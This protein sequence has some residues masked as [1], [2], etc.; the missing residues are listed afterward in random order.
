[1][2]DCQ[3]SIISGYSGM[4]RPVTIV[5]GGLAGLALGIGLRQSD[6]TVTLHEASLYPRHRVCGEFLSGRG[7]QVLEQLGLLDKLFKAGAQTA[8]TISFHTPSKST[9]P[10]PLP[11]P[12]LCLSR[13]RLDHLLAEEFRRSGGH[14]IQNS[15]WTSSLSAEG[16]IRATG[17]RAEQHP[18]ESILGMKIHLRDLPLHS[19][20]EMHFTPTAYFG[21]CRIEDEKV[22][23]CGLF[24]ISDA[25]KELARDRHNIFLRYANHS[26]RDRLRTA[27][28]ELESFCSVA[29]LPLR[30]Q[31]S[32]PKN[33][34]SLGDSLAM[35]PPVTGN[36]MSLALESAHLTLQHALRFS[37]NELSWPEALQLAQSD[38]HRAFSRRL[39]WASQ[40]HN[41]LFSPAIQLLLPG[42]LSR[43]PGLLPFLFHRTRG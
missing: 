38:F 40:L 12:A 27:H 42:A 35:I 13:Y 16:L 21:L 7:L 24:R 19:D 33:E 6:S 39:K 4:P 18:G 15:R 31:L 11:S 10:R 2:L 23:L 36:G 14:L 25:E 32:F 41:L 37:R 22:N 9:S 43:I 5:G 20:L 29:A 3:T 26:L 28:F 34:W 17:R 8:T 1:M 30:Q